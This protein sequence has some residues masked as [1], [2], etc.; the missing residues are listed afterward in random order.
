MCDLRTLTTSLISVLDVDT[1]DVNIT[2]LT[3]KLK[4]LTEC[5]TNASILLDQFS[6]L[7]KSCPEKELRP[8]SEPEFD[9]L[10]SRSPI[11]RCYKNSDEWHALY[12]KIKA[13]ISTVDKQ[14]SALHK[15]SKNMPREIGSKLGVV[16]E[17]SQTHID[18]TS[19]A[20]L[21][22]ENI[23]QDLDSVLNDYHFN[24]Q[25]SLEVDELPEHPILKS[26]A[27]LSKYVK[28]ILQQL[29]IYD[30]P[31]DV[32]MEEKSEINKSELIADTEDLIATM[33]L[34]IQS[35]YK[36]HLPQDSTDVDVLNAIDE[37]IENGDKEKQESNEI[38]E[39]NHLKELLQEKLSSDSKLLK[40]EVLLNKMYN[41]LV[42]YVEFVGTR[43]EDVDEVKNVVMRLVPILEQ[44]VL[45]VQ[46]FVT[47]KVAVHRVSCKML[48]ILLKIFSDLALK[49]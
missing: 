36:K 21:N 11:V 25:L 41:L 13:I 20:K 35:V 7:I 34:I 23:V 39:D 46:Y 26:L 19:E 44:T 47:Q 8:E 33:L 27:N 10:L 40:L 43:N 30:E 45:F 14:R 5:Y 15:L 6:I 31:I 17:V 49:G 37:I 32:S 3:E 9:A 28:D 18:V 1:S 16:P 2:T 12:K 38:L 22:L 4:I 42:K 29:E 48:S 24:L